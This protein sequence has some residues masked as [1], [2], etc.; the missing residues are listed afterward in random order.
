[1]RNGQWSLT[2]QRSD[3]NESDDVEGFS[4]D[5]IQ[6]TRNDYK[7]IFYGTLRKKKNSRVTLKKLS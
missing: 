7:L 6:P 2:R 4:A 3:N 1:M 5:H